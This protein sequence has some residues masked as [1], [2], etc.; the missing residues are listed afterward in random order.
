[1]FAIVGILVLD[2]ARL[3]GFSSCAVLV[4]Y[5]IAH[6]SAI[7]QPAEERWLPRILQVVG[8]AGCLVLAFTLPWQ[9]IVFAAGVLV[10]GLG[11]RM[12]FTRAG[13]SDPPRV[14]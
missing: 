3:V 8:M 4:Y 6:L 9:A 13:T 7:R 10:V 12:L 2:P 14:R 1:M 11:A 5:A